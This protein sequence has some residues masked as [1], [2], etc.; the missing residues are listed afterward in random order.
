MDRNTT[1]DLRHYGDLG[2][3]SA[4]LFNQISISI[5]CDYNN[6]ISELSKPNKDNIYWWMNEVSTRN[7]FVGPFYHYFC[8]IHYI[9]DLIEKSNF[10]FEK[11]IVDSESFK[12]VLE[13]IINNNNI[14]DC[15]I[16]VKSSL[17]NKLK[18]FLKRQIGDIYFF[19]YN[20][21]KL[22]IAKTLFKRNKI[23]KEDLVLIDVFV[24]PGY[25]NSKRWYGSFWDNLSDS[26]KDE[27]FFVST[28]IQCSIFNLVSVFFKLRKSSENYIIK[29]QHLSF[30]D[31]I[32]A[33]RYR[34]K[35]KQFIIN[36]I[37]V[38]GQN[39]SGLIKECILYPTDIY[40]IQEAL[41]T[42]KFVERLKEKNI[43]VRLA[44]D[45][46]EGHSLDKAWNAAFKNYY[47]LTKTIGYRAF[48]SFPLYLCS[49]PIPIESKAGVLPDAFAVQG[50]KTSHSIK[51]FMPKLDTILIPA[52]KADYVWNDFEQNKK[53]S[54]D[55]IL[56]ALP[57]S[58]EIS[59]LI[60]SMIIAIAIKEENKK[61]NFVVKP[62]P[63]ISD[64]SKFNE[65]LQNL[66]KN[67]KFTSEKSFS[68][69][70]YESNILITEASS[71]CL[72]SISMGV[73]VI[74][75][76]IKK[77][78]F[79]NPIPVGLN[80]ELYRFCDSKEDITQSINHYFSLDDLNRNELTL[81][82]Q[83]IRA[84]YFE[85]ITQEGINRFLNFNNQKGG[86][87]S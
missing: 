13:S 62:H 68:K 16:I 80:K 59:K 86:S 6:L 76:R 29:E 82:S 14:V 21:L 57:I 20:F 66:P 64:N 55:Q 38:C 27:I 8:S 72:E 40:T 71:T 2:P 52:F 78:F 28:I 83:K 54:L 31:L 36:D 63:T 81:E 60:I 85:P 58:T 75:I 37:I 12:N 15:I 87:Y 49:Y 84:D 23:K 4:E 77:G 70:L 69:L 32:Y 67:V 26:I 18:K 48:E 41:L 22:I 33:S 34:K 11:I 19:L 56:V 39:F 9:S 45:W 25:T 61:Y 44:I 50:L 35:F 79:F 51:E 42:Y 7:T 17:K 53:Y 3:E 74:I 65:L 73:P 43:S 46:F 1:L 24:I 10:K 47:P 30:N 5:R